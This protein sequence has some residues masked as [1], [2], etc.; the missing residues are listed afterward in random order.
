MPT[1][2][3]LVGLRAAIDPNDHRPAHVHVIGA[4]GEVAVVLHRPD[5]P[6]GDAEEL[7]LLATATARTE[8]TRRAGFVVSARHAAAGASLVL[9]LS[10]GGGLRLPALDGGGAR[11]HG[12]PGSSPAKAAGAK[13]NGQKGGRSRSRPEPKMPVRAPKKAA[14]RPSFSSAGGQAKTGP[15]SAA[16]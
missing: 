8:E 2:L 4:A 9:D 14:Q 5:G 7:R 16:A 3:R 13:A 6:P 12:R 1:V 15:F 10:T 11:R